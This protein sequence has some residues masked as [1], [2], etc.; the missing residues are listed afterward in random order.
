MATLSCSCPDAMMSCETGGDLGA[1]L[2]LLLLASVCALYAQ[3]GGD[4]CESDDGDDAPEGMF[5]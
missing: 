3:C 1:T 5:T 4:E 2:L